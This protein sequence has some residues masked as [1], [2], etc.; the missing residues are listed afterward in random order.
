MT[1]TPYGRGDAEETVTDR[2]RERRRPRAQASGSWSETGRP[3]HADSRIDRDRARRPQVPGSVGTRSPPRAGSPRAPASSR[4]PGRR[5]W[6][7]PV[8]DEVEL[9]GR[10][11]PRAVVADDPGDELRQL[12]R[13]RGAVVS[14][15]RCPLANRLG[16]RTAASNR[17][18]C[19][20]RASG[21]NRSRAGSPD[22]R[23]LGPSGRAV[24]RASMSRHRLADSSAGSG[25]RH[26]R[27]TSSSPVSRVRPISSPVARLPEP[28]RANRFCRDRSSSADRGAWT[29]RRRREAEGSHHRCARLRSLSSPSNVRHPVEPTS[30]RPSAQPPTEPARSWLQI[31]AE[32]RSA[33]VGKV[34]ALPGLESPRRART[35]SRG[36]TSSPRAS[37]CVGVL[38]AAGDRR[39][40]RPRQRHDSTAPTSSRGDG[41]RRTAGRPGRGRRLGCL[42]DRAR[43]SPARSRASRRSS[44]V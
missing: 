22:A 27:N 11:G 3:S 31:S 8:V 40:R 28:P 4:P 42:G 25:T 38:R 12:A 10:S 32:P 19:R 1:R 9:V 33:G 43:S 2:R 35:S 39:P 15:S 41:S 24:A 37:W 17:C 18:S 23:A 5:A 26:A 30:R 16:A 7:H 34:D 13:C 6:R 14:R 20:R 29:A 44:S 36:P 21:H